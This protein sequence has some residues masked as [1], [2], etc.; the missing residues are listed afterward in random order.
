MQE[1]WKK[2]LKSSKQKNA[3]YQEV[4]RIPGELTQQ[5][6]SP[7]CLPV[8]PQR[9]T[10]ILIQEVVE[11]KGKMRRGWNKMDAEENSAVKKG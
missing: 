9:H 6:L 4:P 3:K 7:L 10:N 5:I 2:I 8:P 11:V 1:G